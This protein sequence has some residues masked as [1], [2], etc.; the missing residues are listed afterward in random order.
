MIGNHKKNLLQLI[1]GS[2]RGGWRRGDGEKRS[3]TSGKEIANLIVEVFHYTKL[4]MDVQ[5]L[6]SSSILN[7]RGRFGDGEEKGGTVE[8]EKPMDEMEEKD[9]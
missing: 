8:C 6:Q 2:K 9:F 7:V 1:D 5:S 4:S 3:I